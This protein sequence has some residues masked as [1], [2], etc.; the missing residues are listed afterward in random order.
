[1]G[2]RLV[3]CP[4][5]AHLERIEYAETACGLL[6]LG[7]SR[8]EPTCEVSCPRTCAARLDRRSR[9]DIDEDILAIGDDTS[10]DVLGRLSGG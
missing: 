3:T 2:F 8:F 5:S 4:E 6:I 7:C 10:L 1:M 9:L